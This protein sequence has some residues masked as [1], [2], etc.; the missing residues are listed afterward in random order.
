[1]SELNL[2][3]E[4]YPLDVAAKELQREKIDLLLLAQQGDITFYPHP[5]P[6]IG[7]LEKDQISYFDI[8]LMIIKDK[9]AGQPYR[10]YIDDILVQEH[11]LVLPKEDVIK[12][13]KIFNALP[14]DTISEKPAPK[15]HITAKQCKFI[16][17]LL[18]SH[19]L[20]DN[21]FKGSIEELRRKIAYKIPEID[22]LDIDNK[23]LIDWLKKAEVR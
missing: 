3:L 7:I 13:Y 19:G 17:A 8:G 4:Y 1:M 2:P 16:V 15:I 22:G 12:A 11:D 10:Q 23:T 14:L 20:N 18:K 6:L 9:K 5:D 21:D